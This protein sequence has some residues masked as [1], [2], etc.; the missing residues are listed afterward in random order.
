MYNIYYH[1]NTPYNM[2]A[3][4]LHKTR[5]ICVLWASQDNI[6]M[7]NDKIC[8]KSSFLWLTEVKNDKINFLRRTSEV[9]TQIEIFTIPTIYFKMWDFK[10]WVYKKKQNSEL[11]AIFLANFLIC[12]DESST[13]VLHQWCYIIIVLFA[14]LKCLHTINYSIVMYKTYF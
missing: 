1:I 10:M 7:T 8:K 11:C 12:L 9:L 3:H 13:L 14:N 2:H 4:L 5:T 6:F